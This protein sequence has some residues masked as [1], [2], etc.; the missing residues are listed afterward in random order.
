MGF[1]SKFVSSTILSLFL[2]LL[3]VP[4][5]IQEQGFVSVVISDKGLDFAKDLL[6]EKAISSIIPLQLPQIEKFVKIPVV[7]RVQFVLSNITIYSVDVPSSYVENGE[8]GVV[9]VGSGATAKLSMNWKYSYSTWLIEISD[10]GSASVEVEGM[11]VGV[12]VSFEEQEGTLKLSVLESGCYVQDI[13]IKMNGG[14]SW[15]Y[16]GLVDAFEGK[17]ESLVEDTI[18]SKIREGITE[19]GS[20]LQSLPKQ[21]EV[22]DMAAMNV[23]FVGSPVL[24]NSSIELDINGLFMATNNLVSSFYH[25]GSVELVACEASHK[26]LK[27]SLHEKVFNSV[28][29]VLFNA[30]Y[31]HWIFDKVPDQFL[32]NTSR[33]KYVIPLLYKK[34]PDDAMDLNISVSSPPVVKVVNDDIEMSIYLDVIIDV[35]DADEV[36]PVACVSLEI[37]AS[38]S[39]KIV[40]N[41]LV[42]TLE[43][44]GFTAYLKWS[45]IGNLHIHLVQSIMSLILKT[46]II[47]YA[48]LYLWKGLPLPL[49][50]GFSLQNAEISCTDTKLVIC[51]DVAFAQQFHAF[52]R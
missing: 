11:E 6:I 33:W 46:T 1:F 27:I 31:L 50:H 35:L 30:D 37:S 3:F 9:L 29:L 18:S 49:L 52:S 14:A 39:P 43:L 26:M 21:I 38:C 23:S 20:L 45:K 48:N 44:K 24:S 25:M 42:G 19:L 36:V 8:T 22:Y 12:T 51:S 40:G 28:S 32:L 4:A 16:Q 34:Y 5:S 13:S 17:I 2:L 41:K 7:G 47:P 10:D 15:L